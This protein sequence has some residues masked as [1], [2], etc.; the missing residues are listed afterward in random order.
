MSMDAPF[1]ADTADMR[2]LA[3]A[4]A[5]RVRLAEAGLESSE[6]FEAWLAADAGHRAAWAQVNGPWELLGDHATAPELM[7]ARRNALH[8]AHRQGRRRWLGAFALPARWAVAATVLLACGVG[9]YFWNAQR[10]EVF[11]TALGERRVIPLQDGSRISL[12]SGS[13]VRLRFDDDARRLELRS[14]QARFDVAHDVRRP[15]TVRARDQLVV[16]TGTAFNVDL[17]GAQV[18]VTLIEG[19]VE[20][21]RDAV[22][23]DPVPAPSA[24]APAATAAAAS[25]SASAWRMT[26]N[27]GEQLVLA[28]RR[29]PRLVQVDLARATAWESGQ[30]VFSDEPLAAV[31]QRVGRYHGHPIEVDPGA[32]ALRI[33]GVFRTGDVA[34]FVEVVTRYLPVAAV[35][36]KDGGI[37]LRLRG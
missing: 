12:D 16:A 21:L 17:L 35:P 25:A 33:S 34:T 37:A 32:G 23:S 11:R 28:P 7:A 26:M 22:R 13:E 15:F 6:A 9:T 36:R 1:T 4:A 31:A 27:A 14:G 18:L 2:L 29:A 30:L 3:A 24:A 19:R 8:R 5:W 20:V 10:A